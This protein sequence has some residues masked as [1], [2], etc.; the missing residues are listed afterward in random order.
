[1]FHELRRPGV[2]P[3]QFD[4]SGLASSSTV[5]EVAVQINEHLSSS[6]PAGSPASAPF[7]AP[8]TPLSRLFYCG[9]ELRSLQRTLEEFGIN[10]GAVLMA[11]PGAALKS[12]RVS[13]LE[14]SS[15]SETGGN[16]VHISGQCFRTS[17]DRPLLARFGSTVVPTMPVSG[18]VVRCTSPPHPPG[19]VSVEVSSDGGH[20]WT[21]DNVTYTY[22]GLRTVLDHPIRVPSVHCSAMS[23]VQE[24]E[25]AAFRHSRGL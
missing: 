4:L 8:G 17:V 11:A 23:T 15:G 18:E 1:M 7:D 3:V 5:E 22:I 21:S 6:A 16:S 20:T 14:P 2:R 10:T 9:V 13:Q 12:L 19:P 25:R 24:L